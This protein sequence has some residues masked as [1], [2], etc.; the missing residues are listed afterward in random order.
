MPDFIQ[1]ER[2]YLVFEV[3]LPCHQEFFSRVVESYPRTSNG[4]IDG[5]R[6][7]VTD[8]ELELML[9]RNLADFPI[10][11][12]RKEPRETL[13][14]A[15]FRANVDLLSQSILEAVPYLDEQ[16]AQDL[17][18]P[19]GDAAAEQSFNGVSN[20]HLWAAEVSRIISDLSAARPLS[21]DLVISHRLTMQWLQTVV[22]PHLQV[23]PISGENLNVAVNTLY[24]SRQM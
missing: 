11:V 22:A 18:C 24:L 15:R 1:P 4:L 16:E 3:L 14:N 6:R 13:L 23:R 5:I 9:L 21:P 17:R 8:R 12:Q 19:P 7:G 20:T 2:A 10:H